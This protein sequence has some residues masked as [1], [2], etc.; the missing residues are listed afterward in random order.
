[1]W[2]VAKDA[3]DGL[4]EANLFT[5]DWPDFTTVISQE[6]KPRLSEVSLLAS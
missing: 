5:D 1:M 4:M 6:F 3:Q 2:Q